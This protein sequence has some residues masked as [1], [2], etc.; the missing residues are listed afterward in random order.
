MFLSRRPDCMLG[1]YSTNKHLP[2]PQRTCARP[3]Q[4]QGAWVNNPLALCCSNRCKVRPEPCCRTSTEHTNADRSHPAT[5]ALMKH[6]RCLR[7]RRDLL[8]SFGRDPRKL[9]HLLNV[10]RWFGSIPVLS[11]ACS[12]DW[13]CETAQRDWENLCVIPPLP[14]PRPS[15]GWKCAAERACQ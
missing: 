5:V 3:C 12:A 6:S 10:I 4:R 11:N 14:E 2:H 1:E 7:E 8:Y 15:K 9:S 13:A